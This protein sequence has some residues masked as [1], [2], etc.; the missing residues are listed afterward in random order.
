MISITGIP[1]FSDNYIWML[2]NTESQTCYVIDPGDGNVVQA[3]C[4]QHSVTLAG[5]LITHHHPDHTGGIGLLTS[6][7][8]G[9]C[10]IPVY[11]P[12]AESIKGITHPLADGDRIT[13]VGTEFQVIATPGHTSG[14][15]CYF[16]EPADHDPILFSGDTL[17]AGGCGRLF[18]GTPKQMWHSLSRLAALPDNTRVYCAHE[19]TLANLDFARTVEPGNQQLAQRQQQA[20]LLRKQNHATVP[21]LLAEERKTNPFLRAGHPDVQQ[22]ASRYSGHPVG[23]PEDTFAT[24]RHWKDNF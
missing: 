3:W 10:S 24:I 17:F 15:I 8:D 22:S 12:A 13:V 11:G 5:I 4:Q 19:Y 23:T 20:E 9:K 16:A 14:H 21:S 2:T 1:A 7:A 6:T 18:E